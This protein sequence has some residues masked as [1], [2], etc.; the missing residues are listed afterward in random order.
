MIASPSATIPTAASRLVTLAIGR[1]AE[2]VRV[3]QADLDD[4]RVQPLPSR[5]PDRVR[6]CS[7]LARLALAAARRRSSA[8]NAP[9]VGR[10]EA[11]PLAV[12]GQAEDDVDVGL[13][14]QVGEEALLTCSSAAMTAR[15]DTFVVRSRRPAPPDQPR[16]RR[17][18]IAVDVGGDEAR[19]ALRSS[20]A[21]GR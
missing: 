2:R 13:G 11:D 12:A 19:P 9:S 4:V 21:A 3:R 1:L 7:D 14:E 8:W 15:V 18:A 10:H 6:P 17:A 5:A 20:A 16:G